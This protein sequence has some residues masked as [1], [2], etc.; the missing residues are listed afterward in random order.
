MPLLGVLRVS[1]ASS[2]KKNPGSEFTPGNLGK[3]SFGSMNGMIPPWK[4][5][6]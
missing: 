2:A 6:R 4:D 1:S 3:N 5:D